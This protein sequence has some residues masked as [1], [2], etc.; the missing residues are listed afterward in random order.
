MP[1]VDE[2]AAEVVAES[3]RL[4]AGSLRATSCQ[5]PRAAAV[6]KA[7]LFVACLGED[8]IA[9]YDASMLHPDDAELARWQVPAGPIGIALD[10]ARGRAV[11]WSQFAHA[12]TT[13]AIGDDAG[14]TRPFS[15]ASTSLP[16]EVRTSAKVER[17]RELFHATGD[18]RISGD[19]RACAS[20][21]PDG[22][23]DTLLW[24]SPNGLRQTPMLAGRLEG[25]A[26]YGWNGDAKD[27]STH[28]VST[29]KRLGGKGLTGD[30]K[31]ALMEYVASMRPPPSSRAKRS[32]AAVAVARGAAIFRSAQAGCS[33][34]H[35][36]N[37]DLPDGAAHDV[38]SMAEGDVRRKFDTPSLRFVGGTAPYFHDGRYADLKTLIMRSDAKM[39]HTKQ[40][41]SE[42]VADLAAYLETL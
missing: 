14:V 29:F 16:R 26:P 34:C 40:L 35:G 7:G 12:L 30:D 38:K 6:G 42:D 32:A 36:E 18:R 17:G 10:E 2:D 20:C 23:D 39:G 24:S 13:I 5:L 21:H 8:A 11:V 37:G 25:A 41:S 33:G 31:E 9:L 19:G 4:R 15:I 27:V 22:R 28:L 3:T 1:I